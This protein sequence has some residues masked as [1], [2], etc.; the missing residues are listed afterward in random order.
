MNGHDALSRVI[1]RLAQNS[2]RFLISVEAMRIFRERKIKPP[3]R[4]VVK[5]TGCGQLFIGRA[6]R[7]CLGNGVDEIRQRI[8][9]SRDD[10]IPSLRRRVDTA[11]GSRH[12]TRRP[13]HECPG[14]TA[15]IPDVAP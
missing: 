7:D 6:G 13:E 9:C 14:S 11:C 1:D 4:F 5:I 8:G 15:R 12:T 10:P 2:R 3:L